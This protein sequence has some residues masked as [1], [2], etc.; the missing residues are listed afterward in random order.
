MQNNDLDRT[1]EHVTVDPNEAGWDPAML[2]RPEFQYRMFFK[3]T[4]NDF[5][6]AMD[7]ADLRF[8]LEE[9]C[10]VEKVDWVVEQCSD[11]AKGD[12]ER[13]GNAVYLTSMT[14]MLILELNGE[15]ADEVEYLRDTSKSFWH[16][17]TVIE[18]RSQ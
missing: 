11:Y 17:A 5:Q 2:Y 18:T 3:K 12:D 15:M 4:N 10:G 16:K 8:M 13:Y 14:W 7:L 6:N 9:Q 1:V